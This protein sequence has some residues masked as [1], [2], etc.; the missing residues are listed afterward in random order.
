MFAFAVVTR[1]GFAAGVEVAAAL[2]P[3]PLL[4][5]AFFVDVKA[6]LGT[7]FEAGDGA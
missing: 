2:M 1:W 6:M 5:S 3:S 7:G 4:R